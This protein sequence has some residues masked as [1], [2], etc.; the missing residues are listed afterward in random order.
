MEDNLTSITLGHALLFTVIIP[1]IAGLVLFALPKK[2]N[3]IK[4]ILTIAITVLSCF[5]AF[6]LYASVQQAV[7]VGYCSIILQP[8][9]AWFQIPAEC[10]QY[11]TLNVDAMARLI[12]LLVA[13]FS[14]LIS[15][16]ATGYH[17]AEK[18]PKHFHSLLLLT[19]AASSAAI[20]ADNLMVLIVFWGFLGFTLYAMLSPDDE[21]SS[22]AAKKT[23]ILIGASD[24]LMILG[25]AIIGK[26][27]GTFSMA[28]LD[29]STTNALTVIAF[30]CLAIGAFTKAGAFPFH[31][32]IP[33]YTQTATAP[34]S[35]YLPAA[36]D[37]LLGIYFLTRICHDV[38]QISG[39]IRLTILCLGAL[40]IIIAVMMALI[41]HNY[42]RLLGYHAVSQVGYMITGIGLGSVLGIAG[43]LFHMINNAVYKSGLF[44]AAGCVKSATGKDDLE[45][46]GGLSKAM[47]VTFICS[48]IFALSISGV[49]PLNGFASKWMIYQGIIDLGKGTGPEN[50]LW[51]VWLAMA[52]IGSA[53]T[54]ASFVKF[55]SGIFLGRQKPALGTIQEV[56]PLMWAPMLLLALIC[57]GFGTFATNWVIPSMLEPI[58]GNIHYS[59][60]WNSSLITLLIGISLLLGILFYVIAT[61]GK[62]RVAESFIGGE[63]NRDETGFEPVS[64]YE[65]IRNSLLFKPFYAWAE[66]KYFDVYELSKKLVLDV[67]DLFS[68]AHTGILS[69][70]AF[71]VLAGLIFM[72][73]FLLL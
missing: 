56:N 42:K 15:I 33:D 57:I 73:L 10:A 70:L 19:L 72:F 26:I 41:Q 49:P 47:P 51:M 66:K 67:S 39:G 53:L 24:G 71:W 34:A 29:L 2:S 22:A 28:L 38:F 59:G 32:W 54:L 31:T 44:L 3:R 65:T 5:A 30:L 1:A 37:K 48:L 40:T 27:A 16:Y 63:T 50:H 45:E 11:L 4:D 58:T 7:L 60:L 13:G 46:L 43:G 52:V 62:L 14:L 35:A 21:Q 9:K 6:K 18:K 61:S 20:F 69:N 23:L 8:F 68:K 64:F 55:I 25:I 36:L 17:H 12:I